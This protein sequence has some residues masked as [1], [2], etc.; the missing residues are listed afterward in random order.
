V[1]RSTGSRSG[2]RLYAVHG[3]TTI[4]NGATLGTAV[5]V[6]T[7]HEVGKSHRTYINGSILDFLPPSQTTF[8]HPDLMP[9][10][11]VSA[12]GSP[13]ERPETKTREAV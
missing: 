1:A 5:R 11:R 4:Y 2:G 9:E 7:V 8:T 10:R 13:C 3:G 6:N 12:T